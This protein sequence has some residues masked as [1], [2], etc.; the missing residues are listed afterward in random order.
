MS[1][2]HTIT[3]IILPASVSDSGSKTVQEPGRPLRKNGSL[4]DAGWFFQSFGLYYH[5]RKMAHL[6]GYPHLKLVGRNFGR[7]IPHVDW[8]KWVCSWFKWGSTRT[9]WPWLCV[10][11]GQY[12]IWISAVFIGMLAPEY[13]VSRL[14]D[15]TIVLSWT[16]ME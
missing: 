7:Y 8:V 4:L 10:E 13:N 12:N 16:P 11:V 14:L 5:V 1:Q 6:E 3:L 15:C 9:G 2:I